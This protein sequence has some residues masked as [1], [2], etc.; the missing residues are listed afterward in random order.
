MK[1]VVFTFP[2]SVISD[3]LKCSSYSN[4]NDLVFFCGFLTLDEWI[5]YLSYNI[6]RCSNETIEYIFPFVFGEKSIK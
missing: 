6:D 3:I 2:E 4:I 1:N 5:K